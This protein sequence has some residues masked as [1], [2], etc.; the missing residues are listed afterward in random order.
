MSNMALCPFP[1]IKTGP[2]DS[3][4]SHGPDEYIRLSEIR[5]GIRTY[6]RLLDG[7]QLGKI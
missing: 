7:L 3:A 2:G 1:C 4:R 6:V 5:E